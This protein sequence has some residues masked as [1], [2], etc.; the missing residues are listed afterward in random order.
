MGEVYKARDT[1]LGRAVAI[2]VLP[3][4]LA[5]DKERLDRFEREARLLAALNHP[6]IATLHGMEQS[7]E[8]RFLVMELVE[9]ETLAERIARGAIPLDEAVALFVQIAEGLEAAYERGIVHRDLK[10]AN[11]KISPEGRVKILDFGLAKALSPDVDVS[12]ETS[13]SPTLSKGTALG[14]IMGTASYMSPKQARGKPVDKRTDIWAFG[15]C[16][17]EALTGRK[18]FDGETVSDII[19][20]VLRDEPDTSSLPEQ[21]SRVIERCLT[22]DPRA[23]VRDIGDVRWELKEPVAPTKVASRPSLSFVPWLLLA[24]ATAAALW[25]AFRGVANDVR[26][27]RYI[28]SLP[29]DVRIAGNSPEQHVA[30]SPDG[31]RIVYAVRGRGE[32]LH[33]YLLERNEFTATRIAGTDGA[34]NPFFSPDGN[35]I[36]FFAGG[37]LKKILLAGGAPITICEADRRPGASWGPD[38]T[39]IYPGSH[40]GGLMTVSAGGGEPEALTTLA[41]GET[42]HRWP[43]HLPDGE[44]ILFSI[45]AE[46]GTQIAVE[47]LR[48]GERKTLFDESSGVTQA[49]Y[50]LSGHLLYDQPGS[51]LA[52]AFDVDALETI[53]TPASVLDGAYTH[54]VGG[55]T[56]FAAS[57]AGDVVFLPSSA[58]RVLGSLRELTRDGEWL[59]L[60]EVRRRFGYMA[61]DPEGQRIALNIADDNGDGEI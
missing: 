2:K 55:L 35:W 1:K 53:G 54:P 15:C 46:T 5:Q 10:P 14:A 25:F 40:Q 34:E 20:S 16:L 61:L 19:G 18:A 37:A 58:T 29:E 7:G 38:D 56:H 11:V 36:G 41:S 3:K 12:A 51:L 4:A 57:G 30:F 39:I 31:S 59:E 49:L 45:R 8:L 26:V 47:S 21:G 27:T 28:T 50:L 44:R 6:N 32:D 48:T 52:S 42:G 9:G 22:K 17:Y 13:T 60:S 24:L 33:L 43:Q 23:R